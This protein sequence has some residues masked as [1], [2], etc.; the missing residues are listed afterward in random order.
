MLYFKKDK[1]R[2]SKE[3]RLWSIGLLKPQINTKERP[4]NMIIQTI[5]LHLICFHS[6]GQLGLFFKPWSPPQWEE[7]ELSRSITEADHINQPHFSSS[8]IICSFSKDFRV[9]PL[10]CYWVYVSDND[11]KSHRWSFNLKKKK[12]FSSVFNGRHDYPVQNPFQPPSKQ[13]DLIV[14]YFDVWSVKQFGKKKFIQIVQ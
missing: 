9:K 14:S 13:D 8:A 6:V 11:T 4:N 5:I 10:K 2:R 7:E 1:W 3:L 12:K